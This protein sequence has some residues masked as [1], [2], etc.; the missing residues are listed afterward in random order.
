M[1]VAIGSSITSVWTLGAA[2]GAL[3]GSIAPI[4]LHERS[5]REMWIG[6]LLIIEKARI[7]KRGRRSADPRDTFFPRE[8]IRAAEERDRRAS[9]AA[10]NLLSGESFR[11]YFTFMMRAR[12]RYP[13]LTFSA[14]Y[15]RPLTFCTNFCLSSFAS[16]L[17]GSRVA[18]N[19][20]A[21]EIS[22]LLADEV[23]R[24][25]P[26]NAETRRESSRRMIYADLMGTMSVNVGFP[27]DDSLDRATAVI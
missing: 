6:N 17:L 12:A 16:Y 7:S 11:L 27:R 1:R 26:R 8:A 2:L 10:V 24:S 3:S 19:S 23:G 21:G 5:R 25:K 20:P 15:T 9:G 18:G 14:R 4:D 22:S 13:F